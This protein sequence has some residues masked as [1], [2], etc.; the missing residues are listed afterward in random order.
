MSELLTHGQKLGYFGVFALALGEA[1]IKDRRNV[2][3][4][5]SSQRTPD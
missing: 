2:V 5:H 4:I 1:K 3:T